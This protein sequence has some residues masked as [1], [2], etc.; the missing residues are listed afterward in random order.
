MIKLIRESNEVN[1]GI[2]KD[3]FGDNYY[4]FEEEDINFVKGLFNNN[5]L[6]EVAV[7]NDDLGSTMK[8]GLA[9]TNYV[10]RGIINLT[11]E[12]RKI[13]NDKYKDI[14][15][16]NFNNTGSILWITLPYEEKY[17]DKIQK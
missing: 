16:L 2:E 14:G 8:V 13:L 6:I 1:E 3:K 12:F 9:K 15:I 4:K 11:D 5:E 10:D 7:K 17:K